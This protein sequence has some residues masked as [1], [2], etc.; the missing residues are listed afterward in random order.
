MRRIRIGVLLFTVMFVLLAGGCAKTEKDAEKYVSDFMGYATG[1]QS[2]EEVFDSETKEE[3][4]KE[5]IEEF[6][7]EIE[8]SFEEGEGIPS[9]LQDRL[10]DVLIKVM[11]KTRYTVGSAK[12]TEDGFD[13]PVMIEPMQLYDK[14]Y[15][16]VN[17][18][19]AEYFSGFTGDFD[20]QKFIE[21]Y[22]ETVVDTF[23]E[24]SQNPG[25]G[26]PFEFIVPLVVVD[27]HFEIKDEEKT[28]EQLGFHMADNDFDPFA[29][30]KD[31]EYFKDRTDKILAAALSGEYD[32]SLSFVDNIAAWDA[33]DIYVNEM[34]I[35]QEEA[36]QKWIAEGTPADL[37]EVESSFFCAVQKLSKYECG[38]ATEK[39]GVPAITVSVTVPDVDT[40][41]ENIYTEISESITEEELSRFADQEETVNYFMIKSFEEANKRI[42]EMPYMEPKEYAVRFIK[43]TDLELYGSEFEDITEILTAMTLNQ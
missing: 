37:A 33:H 42:N 1:Q 13:V 17:R 24:V 27:D 15:G 7:K 34:V 21:W 22:L 25:Y 40:Y 41:L 38:D 8:S 3:V 32:E 39:D 30:E 28:V 19:F 23:E 35:T 14:L 5:L 18:D 10:V 9:D 11:K 20:E 43:N 12:K 36:K 6:E 2:G 26:E 16:N 31:P 29:R 4:R